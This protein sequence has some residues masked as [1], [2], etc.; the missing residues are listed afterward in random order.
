MRAKL[1]ATEDPD[2]AIKILSEL[3]EI[4]R[5]VET[6]LERARREAER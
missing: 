3:A 6:E 2:E 1:E 4:A 5:Q